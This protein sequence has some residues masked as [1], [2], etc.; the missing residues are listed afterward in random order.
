M[1]IL[2]AFFVSNN[3]GKCSPFLTKNEAL[4][5]WYVLVSYSQIFCKLE[6]LFLG[7]QQSHED[8]DYSEVDHMVRKAI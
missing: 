1:K 5:V 2:K 8:F 6:K 3:K 7:F 4:F